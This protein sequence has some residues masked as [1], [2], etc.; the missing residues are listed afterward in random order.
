MQEEKS[1]VPPISDVVGERPGEDTLEPGIERV[2]EFTV[3]GRLVTDVG[4]T[5]GV[6]VLSTPG[7]IALMERVSAVLSAARCIEISGRT[8]TVSCEVGSRIASSGE[9][10][11]VISSSEL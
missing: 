10:Y 4:G 7:M 8:E 5:I 9:M 11:W 3:E 1:A 2:D 6:A